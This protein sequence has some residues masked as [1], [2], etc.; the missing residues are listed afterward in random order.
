[1][2]SWIAA[3]HGVA[4]ES[5]DIKSKEGGEAN[6]SVASR[7]AQVLESVD[8]DLVGCIA[9]AEAGNPHKPGNLAHGDIER[10]TG[11]EGGDGGERDKVDDKAES[12]YAES[13]NNGSD[14]DSESGSDD[15]ARNVRSLFCG[16]V[17]DVAGQ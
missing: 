14:Q 2:P 17:D 10:G 15:M 4:D 1:M 3:S 8:E 16:F 13:K 11:H 12:K 9:C 5:D 7:S 6:C